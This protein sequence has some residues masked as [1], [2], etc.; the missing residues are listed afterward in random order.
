MRRRVA[1]AWLL[2]LLAVWGLAAPVGAQTYSSASVGYVNIDS[3]THTK[4]GANTA[5]YKFVKASGCPTTPPVID[6]T[7][8]GPIPIGFNF[9]YGATSWN[10][11]Y[12]MTNG[13]LQFGNTTCGA[14]TNSIGP[15]QTYP[16]G[17][18]DASMNNTMKVF[19]VDLD[20][21]NLAERAN[22]P[23]AGAKTPCTSLATC[24]VSVATIGSAP[25]RQFV[26]SWKAVPEWVNASNTSGRFDLQVI[27]NEDGSFV[28]QYGSITHGGTGT[29]QIGWQLSST[30]YQVL[31]FG[32]SLEPPALS[33]IKFFLPRPVSSH[34]FDEAV[35]ARGLAGQVKDNG[36]FALHGTALGRAQTTAGGKV[37][38]AADIPANSTPTA[39]DGVDTGISLQ[40]PALSLQGTGTLAFWYRHALPW[41]GAGASAVQLLDASGA[42]GAWFYLSKRANGSLVFTVRDSSGVVRSVTSPTQSFGANTWVHIALS[43]DFNGASGTN[44]D[45]LRIHLNGAA[46]TLASFTADGALDPGIGNI[47]MGDNALGVADANGSLNS[48]Q[49]QIDE[50][51]A[52]NFVL[53]TTQVVGAMNAT[54]ACPSYS[55]DHLEIDYPGGEVLTC[56]Q[57]TVTV[58]ACANAACS[59]PYVGGLL[60]SFTSSGAVTPSWDDASGYASGAG[61]VIPN[62]SSSVTKNLQ[63]PSAGSAQLAASASFPSASGATRCTFGSPSCTLQSKAAVLSLG[64]A[65]HRAEQAQTL[66]V[67]AGLGAQRCSASWGAQ[68]RTLLLRCAYLNPGS[69]SLPVRVGGRA[70]NAGNNPGLACDGSG[71]SVSVSFDASAAASLSLQYADAGQVQLSASYAG[72]GATGDTGLSLAGSTSFITVPSDFLIDNLPAGALTAGQA[73]AARATA[74]N[75]AGARTPNFGQESPQTPLSWTHARRE[76]TAAGAVD[77]FLSGGANATAG[78]AAPANLLWSEVGRIDLVVS[79]ANVL[80]SGL[81]VTGSS[82]AAGAL[83]PFR[84]QHLRVQA[85]EACGSYSYA[86]QP[87]AVTLTAM[88]ALGQP[89]LNYFSAASGSSFARDVTLSDGGAPALGLGSLDLPLVPASAF[90][91]GQA[92]HNLAYV[93]TSK[94]SG[95]G[96]LRLRATDSDGVSSAAQ[97][98]ADDDMA[99]RSGRLMLHS[100]VGVA[101]QALRLPL[102]LEQWKGAWVLNTDDSCTAPSAAAWAAAIAQSGRVDRSGVPTSAWSTPVQAVSLVSGLGHVRLAAPTP[103]GSGA[104]D[105]AINLG[106]TGV[107]RACLPAHP[108]T[109]GLALP[110]LRSR[111]GSVNGCGTREDSDPSARASFGVA[112]GHSPNKIHERVVD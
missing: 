29:A 53:S 30:D 15:P 111:Q 3:S 49:G 28:Y 73:F 24:Y 97:A 41:S 67:T 56:S 103:S 55:V 58:R 66:S 88:N 95:P 69:G 62:G 82:G 94:A 44:K 4:I 8:A 31:S 26:V 96:T 27:L 90:S 17:Y 87:F 6:D 89:T 65:H 63:L 59:A 12:V 108:A 33:A 7:L 39:V 104:L 10:Q 36:S 83:G 19:G 61:F 101:S 13:R 9:L 71:Q 112:P 64:V 48:A 50:L 23:S 18:P 22:Y 78:I 70:L 5:P 43:W 60:G 107:D 35:W 45:G 98:G 85:S 80:G 81:A 16:Y 74:R 47:V 1:A 46:P 109:S 110:W 91:A 52:Y 76:P 57:A 21:T 77:G 105:L 25:N 84:P 86:G 2:G 20:P 40:N 34:Y 99:L 72:S 79:A 68:P 37:C 14:G 54:H 93:F 102:R 32:A 42:G 38:R 51:Y 106:S 75:A 11:V 92:T 100:A